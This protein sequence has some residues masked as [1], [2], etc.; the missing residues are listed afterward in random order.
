MTRAR[1]RASTSR[2]CGSASRT[3][4]SSTTRCR[5]RPHRSHSCSHFVLVGRRRHHPGRPGRR[6]PH[7]PAVNGAAAGSRHDARAGRPDRAPADRHRADADRSR[8]SARG[9]GRVR[10]GS[11]WGARRATP[12]LPTAPEP[13]D[14]SPDDGTPIA[15]TLIV[16]RT[17]LAQGVALGRGELRR[18][19]S[20]RVM[21]FRAPRP[22]LRVVAGTGPLLLSFDSEAERDR[23]AAELLDEA[24]LAPDGRPTGSA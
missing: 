21:T 15:T 2:R 20:G 22:A 13:A 3:G 12:E 24:G 18:I 11:C 14:P 5:R 10:S 23:A 1:P 9:T 8:A 16:E 19:S 7:L 4:T 6:L 17:G